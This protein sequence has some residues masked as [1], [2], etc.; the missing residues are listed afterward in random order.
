MASSSNLGKDLTPEQVAC[1]DEWRVL[2]QTLE[3]AQGE[4]LTR[5]CR[6][7]YQFAKTY[8]VFGCDLESTVEDVRRRASHGNFK[9]FT[10]RGAPGNL[11]DVATADRMLRDWRRAVESKQHHA[12]MIF[13][14]KF[15][16]AITD[17]TGDGFEAAG[18]ATKMA[19]AKSL[20]DNDALLL[21]VPPTALPVNDSQEYLSG[22]QIS[23]LVKQELSDIEQIKL[24]IARM[25]SDVDRI[26]TK[27][28]LDAS[29]N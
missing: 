19:A 25:R 9:F 7:K 23:Q 15:G 14:S 3:R 21:M 5:N 27:L 10:E 22:D 11:L 18:R 8:M 20:F 1:C 12:E 2:C 28:D 16:V 13:Q 24:E 17:Y 26:L 6:E 29:G 4:E